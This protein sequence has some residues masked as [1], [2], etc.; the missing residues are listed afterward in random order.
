MFH[1]VAI[2]TLGAFGALIAYAYAGYPALL[3]MA[4]RRPSTP[5]LALPAELPRVTILVA[6]Y[7]EEAQIADTIEALLRLDYP[8]DRRQIIIASDASTDRTDE[9]VRSFADRGVEL[10]RLERRGG[11]TTAENAAAAHVRGDI[12]VN[13]DASTRIRSDALR[14]MIAAFSDPHIGVVSGTDVSVS[15]LPDD[16]SR[17]EAAYVQYEMWVR[18]L[19]TR[20]GGIVGASGC[21]FAIRADLHRT[22]APA[23]LSRDFAAALDAEEQGYRSISMPAAICYVPRSNDI[24]AEYRRKVRTFTRGMETLAFKKH[25]LNPLRDARFAW[26][27]ISHKVL[28]WVIPWSAVVAYVALGAVATYSRVALALFLLVSATVVV[29]MAG[30]A[31]ATP[32]RPLP[33]WLALPAYALASNVAVL[34][35]TLYAL[36]GEQAPTW[37]PT[38]RYVLMPNGKGWEGAKVPPISME[39]DQAAGSA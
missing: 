17:G 35:A 25:L 21:F 39:G 27:L 1:T 8:A 37:E 11:K 22:P 20:A 31:V 3:L 2:L 26:K 30:W 13:T 24:Q 18:A 5:T 4:A 36:G 7:N 14:P 12:V 29:G 16:A 19:E 33:R 32:G 10:V 23:H 9:I 34:R 28:R 6:A 15:A 38:R